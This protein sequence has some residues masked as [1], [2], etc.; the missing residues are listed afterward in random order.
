MIAHKKTLIFDF[1]GTLANS[2]DI[3]IKKM[4]LLSKIYDFNRI[5]SNEITTLKNMRAQEIAKYLKISITKSPFILKAYRKEMNKV[6]GS[7]KPPCGMK[8]Q[9]Y[10]L[11]K[12][13]YNMGIVSSNSL[14][15]VLFFLRKNKID[16]FFFIYTSRK[17]WQINT[18]LKYLIKKN[19]LNIRDL[20]Y[21]A[22]ETRDIEAAKKNGVKIIA[23][24]WGYNANTIL[25]K[26]S[27]DYLISQPNELINIIK[28]NSK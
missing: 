15:N 21:I 4:N 1:D 16:F 11:H 28:R 6:I 27:P 24:S 7:I 18:L 10:F 13:K 3:F 2:F 5:E 17:N 12:E 22:D 8:E 25:Q 26:Y 9:L 14:Q 23:V 19:K 20:L